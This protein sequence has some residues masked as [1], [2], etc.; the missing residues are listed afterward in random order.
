I[1]QYVEDREI[2]AW[3]LLDLSPSIDYGTG[4]S[5]KRSVLINFVGTLSRLLTRQGNRVGAIYY[6]NHIEKIIPP[7]GG[8]LQVLRLMNDLLEN[9]AM[10]RSPLT[11]LTPLLS[12]S[13]GAIKRRSLVFVVSDFFCEPGWEKP[14]NLLSQ[15]HEVV[16]VRLWDASETE[17]PQSGA[18]IV[19]DAETGEQLYVDTNDKKFRSQFI[20]LV[21]KHEEGLK[22]T[23]KRAGVDLLSI[24][25]DD[26]LVRA[27]M[28]FT[29]F[30]QQRRRQ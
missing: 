27:I 10:S 19:E 1:R 15:K 12:G 28:R 30:R 3:F 4:G 7:G 26:D 13:L 29:K 14:F 11:D 8:R 24:S 25:T 5:D 9:P 18:M 21:T 22:R 2:S 16:G 20:E 17:L 6:N 23:F